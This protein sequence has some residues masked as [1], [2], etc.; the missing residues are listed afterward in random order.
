MSKMDELYQ[1]GYEQM[2]DF[3]Q[4]NKIHVSYIK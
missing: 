3:I 2:N 4:K 1:L